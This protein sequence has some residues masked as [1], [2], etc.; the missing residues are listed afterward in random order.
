M[1]FAEIRQ[2]LAESLETIPRLNQ[3]A[4]LLSQPILPQAEIEPGEIEYDQTFARG[5]DKYTLTIRVTVGMPSNIGAQKQLDRMLAPSGDYSVKAAVEA[6]PS[7]GGACEDLRVTLCTGYRVYVREG[8][9]PA[10]G[11]EW[12]VEVFAVGE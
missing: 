4:Y 3:S 8:G 11:A 5:Q 9:P 6:D 7:L 2:G 10:L 1:G 12:R